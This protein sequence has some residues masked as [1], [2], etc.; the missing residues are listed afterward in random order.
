MG[1]PIGVSARV[2]PPVKYTV[3][4]F[5]GPQA[6]TEPFVLV[7]CSKEY[8]IAAGASLEATLAQVSAAVSTIPGVG[9][10]IASIVQLGYHWY[11]GASLNSDGSVNFQFAYHYCGTKAGG[12]DLTATPLPG[13][14][15]RLWFGIVNGLIR[16]LKTLT[17]DAAQNIGIERAEEYMVVA[18]GKS[19]EGRALFTG[20]RTEFAEF[21]KQE[22]LSAQQASELEPLAAFP[23]VNLDT[24]SYRCWE[25]DPTYTDPQGDC[26]RSDGTT[27][28]WRCMICEWYDNN[29]AIVDRK[30]S[31]WCGTVR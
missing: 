20:L 4:Y 21:A 30:R 8:V 10:A 22:G 28:I 19:P 29:G 17:F 11:A 18:P 1:W 13:V 3:N 14:D 9:A 26:K 31:C 15:P 12:I 27:G 5:N 7:T 2:T 6:Y 24:S 23:D 25:V 16:G